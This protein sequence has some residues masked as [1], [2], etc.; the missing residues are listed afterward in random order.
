MM[1][2]YDTFEDLLA[3]GKMPG[4]SAMFPRFT[5]IRL[6]ITCYRFYL[7]R[8]MSGAVICS[9]GVRDSIGIS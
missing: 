6:A 5:R 3:R 9:F 7:H 1:E 2:I 4:R 8:L